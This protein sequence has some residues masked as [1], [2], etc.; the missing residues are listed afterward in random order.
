MSKEKSEQSLVLKSDDGAIY[1]I[2]YSQLESFRLSEE[3]AKKVAEKV[4]EKDK[5]GDVDVIC[6]VPNCLQ[7]TLK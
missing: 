2:P 3:E 5:R 4:A 1:R 6:V 7:C